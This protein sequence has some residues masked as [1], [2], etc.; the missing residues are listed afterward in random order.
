MLKEK[1]RS[2]HIIRLQNGECTIDMGFI[3]SD[4]LTSFERTSDHCSNIAGGMIDL[5]N[6]D[7]NIHEHLRYIKKNDENFK[8][9]LEAYTKKYAI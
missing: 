4:L 3:L 1:I 5:I 8:Q 2:N 6:H 9:Q 7:M